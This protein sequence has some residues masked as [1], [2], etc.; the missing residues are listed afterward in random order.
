MVTSLAIFFMHGSLVDLKMSSKSVIDNPS[1]LTIA[2]YYNVSGPVVI[3]GCAR[4]TELLAK[5]ESW[6]ND[7]LLGHLNLFKQLF[8]KVMGDYLFTSNQIYFFAE[9]NL[10]CIAGEHL[11][12]TILEWIDYTKPGTAVLPTGTPECC[13]FINYWREYHRYPSLELSEKF[14]SETN[15]YSVEELDVKKTEKLHSMLGDMLLN[16]LPPRIATFDKKW[17]GESARHLIEKHSVLAFSSGLNKAENH[18]ID[19]HLLSAGN[20]GDNHVYDCQSEEGEVSGESV[21]PLFDIATKSKPSASFDSIDPSSSRTVSISLTFRPI[22]CQFLATDANYADDKPR[23]GSALF[24]PS[25]SLSAGEVYRFPRYNS[26]DVSQLELGRELD[27]TKTPT[28]RKKRKSFTL[29]E[30]CESNV[31]VVSPS[32]RPAA[33][34]IREQGDGRQNFERMESVIKPG[35]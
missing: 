26:S 29:F 31:D 6:F 18:K 30:C 27:D 19:E 1:V 20:E 28:L 23:L 15:Y 2:V 14:F 13:K 17:T 24:R 35:V 7:A 32:T 9:G 3:I 21:S 8:D 22:Q 34:K 10:G 5:K 11:T 25:V 33:L 4:I 16:C 12:P